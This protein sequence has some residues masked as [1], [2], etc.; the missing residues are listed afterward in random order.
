MLATNGVESLRTAKVDLKI[1]G[2]SHTMLVFV[3][4][5]DVS[6]VLLGMDHP[7]VNCWIT[8]RSLPVLSNAPVPL[9]AITWAQNQALEMEDASSQ[10]ASTQSGA[11]VKSLSPEQ[12]KVKPKPIKI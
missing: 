1:D 4:G 5:K 10:V 7:F 6:H 9:A 3:I 12:P 11:K 8:R 2:I